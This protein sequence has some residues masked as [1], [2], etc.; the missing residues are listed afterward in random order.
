M[1]KY[2]SQEVHCQNMKTRKLDSRSLYFQVLSHQIKTRIASG[3][4]KEVF[5]VII[6]ISLFIL[7]KKSLVTIKYRHYTIIKK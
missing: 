4:K 1:I 5:G 3:K 7:S 2:I 6:I